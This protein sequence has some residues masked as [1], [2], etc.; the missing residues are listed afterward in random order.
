[1]TDQEIMNAVVWSEYDEPSGVG[2]SQENGFKPIR[3]L[4][5]SLIYEGNEMGAEEVI[6]R[7]IEWHK[8]GLIRFIRNRIT[9]CAPQS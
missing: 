1:M 6:E 8:S 5:A 3:W 7:E 2:F 4:R 9:Q